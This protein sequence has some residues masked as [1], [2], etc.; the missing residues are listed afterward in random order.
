[1][2]KIS[3]NQECLSITNCKGGSMRSNIDQ[4][5]AIDLVA[6][7]RSCYGMKFQKKGNAFVCLSPFRQER[8]PSFVIHQRCEQ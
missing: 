1:M 8:N 3:H 2:K 7:C 5:K 4:L 6:F